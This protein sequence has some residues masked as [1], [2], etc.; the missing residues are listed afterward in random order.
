MII[1]LR[2]GDAIAEVAAKRGEFFGWMRDTVGCA[3][4]GAWREHDVRA[5]APHPGFEGVTGFVITGSASSVTERAPWMLR[6]EEYVRGIH[7]ARIPLLGICFGHQLIAQAL[8][9]D[10]QTNPRGRE[11]GTVRARRVHAENEGD[12]FMGE[13]EGT[14]FYTGA[15]QFDY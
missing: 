9:G 6:A 3:W 11:I 8:G 12:V 4:P 13:I 10:V 7:A 2:T 5:D 1:V 15:A 14:P